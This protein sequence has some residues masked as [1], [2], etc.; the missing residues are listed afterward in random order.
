MRHVVEQR[1]TA[2]AER[3]PVEHD[4]RGR[5][6]ELHARG[7]APVCGT[8]RPR[9]LDYKSSSDH[10][11]HQEGRYDVSANPSA[12]PKDVVSDSHARRV[13]PSVTSAIVRS[14]APIDADRKSILLP[15][16][17]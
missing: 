1:A 16:V 6:S 7:V 11:K 12:H 5:A 8:P 10:G 3:T 15:E 4:V 17:N 9:S 14:S 13:G 2:D